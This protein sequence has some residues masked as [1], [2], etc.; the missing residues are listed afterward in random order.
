MSVC[1]L[2]GV[3]EKTEDEFAFDCVMRKF[4][5]QFSATVIRD[6]SVGQTAAKQGK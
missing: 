5:V 2:G 4:F 3:D 6:G 1:A